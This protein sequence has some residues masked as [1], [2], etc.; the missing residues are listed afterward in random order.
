MTICTPKSTR[1]IQ[2]DDTVPGGV[3]APEPSPPPMSDGTKGSS[4]LFCLSEEG[5]MLY[6]ASQD[7]RLFRVLCQRFEITQ[8]CGNGG[9]LSV[10]IDGMLDPKMDQVLDLEMLYLETGHDLRGP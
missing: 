1:A 9:T 2:V 7:G 10:S 8:D 4:A 5:P 6:L 3:S